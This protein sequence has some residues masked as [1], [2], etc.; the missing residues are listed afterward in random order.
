MK[1]S[2]EVFRLGA[3]KYQYPPT[4]H[5]LWHIH[6]RLLWQD[7]V[8]PAEWAVGV[9]GGHRHSTV[10]RSNWAWES[11]VTFGLMWLEHCTGYSGSQFVQLPH[12]ALA[13]CGGVKPSF[14]KGFATCFTLSHPTGCGNTPTHT[15]LQGMG[16]FMQLSLVEKSK[17]LGLF[18]FW[19]MSLLF[20]HGAV[21]PREVSVRN[22]S[23][24][25]L[26]TVIL[27]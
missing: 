18:Y 15:S 4:I 22:C 14:C 12:T 1:K 27:T 6:F 8:L 21:K 26:N 11:G 3:H 17:F 9:S 25:A 20:T 10:S 7:L 24:Y 16:D 2:R 19:P 23:H 5:R 13:G